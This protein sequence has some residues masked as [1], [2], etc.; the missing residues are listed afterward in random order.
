MRI[1][2]ILDVVYNHFS[3]L[4]ERLL[5]PFASAYV[6]QRHKNEWGALAEFRR[7]AIGRGPRIISGQR[8]LLDFRISLRRTA[9]R[10]HSGLRG[11]F[12]RI[13]PAWHL[14]GQPGRRPSDRRVLIVGEN[15]PQN[16]ESAARRRGGRLWIRCRVER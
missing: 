13:D 10:R 4:G 2:V 1:G 12:G 11:R 7:R 5:R 15:E 8:D 14:A 9:H 16:A 6:S 3:P